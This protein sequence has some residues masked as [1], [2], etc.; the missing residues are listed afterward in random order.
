M[1]S[2]VGIPADDFQQSLCKNE[3]LRVREAMSCAT[4]L[5]F[6][7]GDKLVFSG[8]KVN[9]YQHA[10]IPENGAAKALPAGR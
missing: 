2:K 9:I 7:N 4:E 1:T 6:T 3:G 10:I 5:P 8:G